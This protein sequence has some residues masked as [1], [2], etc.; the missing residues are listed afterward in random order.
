MTWAI[1]LAIAFAAFGA[2][3]FVFRIPRLGW[4]LAGAAL[5]FGIAGYALQGHPGQPGSPTPPRENAKSDSEALIKARQQM[6]ESYGQSAN[7]MV[8]ADGLARHGEFR[9]AAEVLGTAVKQNPKDADL[10][11]ALGNAL[12]EHSDGMITPAA[13][14]AFQ[15]A[16]N[17]DP[18]HPGP[19][20][21]MGLALAQ[22]GRLADARAV[23]QQLLD[24]SPADAPYRQDLE[25]RIAR[26]DR[27]L[28]AQAPQTPSA[29]D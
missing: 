12:V 11:V 6:G 18:Q 21:F 13:Q 7:W 20:F 15:K 26:I 17:I 9:A 3:V 22:S 2:M 8:L 29:G 19:P 27:M 10:W 25:A 14:F 5:L 28:A 4:E 16:A 1:I 24:R 23:W